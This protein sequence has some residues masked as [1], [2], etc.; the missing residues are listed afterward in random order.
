MRSILIAGAGQ[1]GLNLALGLQA[2]NYDVTVMTD[3]S[4]DKIRDG[5]VLSTQVIAGF[6]PRQPGPA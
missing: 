6:D 3:H 1:A 4:P 5:R 2:Q